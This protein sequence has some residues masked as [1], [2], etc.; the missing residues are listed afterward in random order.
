MPR[1]KFAAEPLLKRTYTKEL[2]IQ[3]IYP[4]SSN[5]KSWSF[6][7][8]LVCR[9]WWR[10]GLVSQKSAWEKIGPLGEGGQSDVSLVRKPE[11]SMELNRDFEFL[12]TFTPTSMT[13]SGDPERLK[14]NKEF[15]AVL[16]S[17]TRSDLPEELGA[18]KEFKIRDNE[19]QS[20]ERLKQEIEILSQDRP[21]LPK[22]L[23]YNEDERWLVTEYFSKGTLEGHMGTYKGKPALALKAFQT[24]VKTIAK[25]HEEGIVH[26]DIKPANVFVR[27]N[28]ELVLGDF[29][30]VYVPNR[31]PRITFTGES[32]G[33]SDF[34]PEWAMGARLEK[35]EANFDIYML[36][37][38]LWCMVSGRP[39]LRREYFKEP[40]N[41]LTIT[42]RGDPHMNMI[43]NILSHCVVERQE[44][45][46]H[47]ALDLL[48][49]VNAYVEVIER[50]GQLL[51]EEVPRPCRV[52]GFGFYNIQ[53]LV[54][55]KTFYGLRFWHGTGTTMT[56]IQVELFMCD[57]CGH[58]ELFRTKDRR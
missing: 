18:M 29:G 47:S 54:P 21:G 5:P 20:L 7:F 49:M 25:L 39:V 31:P 51:Q 23:D 56:T 22:L 14:S 35:V 50:G 4:P 27:E 2:G 45:C 13:G 41:N 15:I 9:A 1:F 12:R 11:R 58:T 17:C 30:I 36:G 33:A 10:W 42:Y 28:H 53:T 52:C 3:T 46:F 32:V 37:K 6:I 55:D 26:R 19:Q 38:L 40:A 8:V 48:P 16:Q 34:M 57:Q 43:N 44:Q 24:L